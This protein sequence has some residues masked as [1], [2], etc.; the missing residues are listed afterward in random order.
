MVKAKCATS[1]EIIFGKRR[2][3]RRRQITT[4]K[5][6]LPD[7]STWFIISNLPGAIYKTVGNDYGLRTWVESGFKH[8]QNH[9]GW[10]DRVTKSA[11]IERWWE[12][13]CSVYLMV[14]LQFNR[15]NQQSNQALECHQPNF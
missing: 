8:A 12:V 10:A 13:A 11:Q 4:D 3:I 15:L 14:S 2:T 7:N 1:L 5:D 6:K 9:L